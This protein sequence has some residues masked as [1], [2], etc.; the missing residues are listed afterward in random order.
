MKN[1]LR[2]L[3]LFTLIMPVCRA[4][5]PQ[6]I[7]YSG[8]LSDSSGAVVPDG[9]YTV[10]FSIYDDATNGN[11]V[12]QEKATISIMHGQLHHH[13]GTYEPLNIKFIEPL[14]LGVAIDGA[15]EMLPRLQF[16]A[17]AYAFA[18]ETSRSVTGETNFFP[19]AGAVGIGLPD[20][21]QKA[22]DVNGVIRSRAG[23]FEFPDGSVQTSAAA[24]SGGNSGN[25]L[26]ASDGEP[27]NAVFVDNDG[28][29]GIGTTRPRAGFHVEKS[30]II[31]N[32]HTRIG[33]LEIAAPNSFVHWHLRTGDDVP[34][35]APHQLHFQYSVFGNYRSNFSLISNGNTIFHNNVGIGTPIPREKLSVNGRIRAKEVIVTQ[36]NWPDFVFDKSYNLLPLAAVEKFIAEKGHLPDMP[37]AVEVEKN[38]VQL[39]DLQAKLLQKIEELTL[40]L[41][42]L[43]K[44]NDALE[45]R[46][47]AIEKSTKGVTHD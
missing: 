30:E 26:S 10:H 16:T 12:W 4:Q 29:V 14:W 8:V 21:A 2:A 28:D 43:K 5:I 1:T 33:K 40:H 19:A 34:G 11:L 17:A 23:G 6:L 31:L 7:S 41:I 13:L 36:K 9:E 47:A 3:V 25:S 18:A 45:N 35:L 44:E 32:G 46:I 27:E 37:S 42:Q 22:L 38:D 39:G 15:A 24:G 20:S